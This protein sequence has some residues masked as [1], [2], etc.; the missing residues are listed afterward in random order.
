MTTSSRTSST[1]QS[2][3]LVLLRGAL[4]PELFEIDSRARIMHGD[5]EFEYWVC[6]GGHVL[7]FENNGLCLTEVL[8]EQTENLSDR[9]HIITLPCAGEKDFET[10]LGNRLVYMTSMQ[11]ET[12]R[13]HLFLDTYNEMVD[14]GQEENCITC[15]WNDIHGRPNLSA[16]EYQRYSNE[17]H[18]QG[19]HMRSNCGLILRSQTIFQVKA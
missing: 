2:Y 17:V 6:R 7:R 15:L 3:N 10:E 5:Y 8:G 18:I 19:Y 11:T 1:L 16:I 4:H 13:G 14:H 9:G 12:L